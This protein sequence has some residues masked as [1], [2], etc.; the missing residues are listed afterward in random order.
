MRAYTKIFGSMT[1]STLRCLNSCGIAVMT[2][3]V[4]LSSVRVDDRHRDYLKENIDRLYQ[5]E[6]FHQL[7]R[8]LNSY[9]SRLLF[10]LL[11]GLLKKLA[12]K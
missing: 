4:H 8:L 5:C 12:V 2:V 7:I 1:K 6:N 9:W 3:I 11:G 10:D